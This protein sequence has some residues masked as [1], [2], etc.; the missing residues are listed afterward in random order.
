MKTYFRIFCYVMII[1][2]FT[3]MYSCSPEDQEKTNVLFIAV[4]D[5]RPALACYGDGLA[6]TPNIDRLA[7]EGALFTNH[8][9]QAP[10]C[11][12]SRTSMLTGYRPDEVKVTNHATH[13]RD[14][15][16]EVVTLPELFKKEGYTTISLGKIF[17]YARGYNDTQSWDEEHFLKG[18]MSGYILQENR[19]IKGKAASSECVDVPDTAYLDGIIAEKAI[20]CLRSFKKN[21]TSFFLAAGFLKPHLPFNA[22]KK[23]WDLYDREIF[24]DIDQRDPPENAPSIAFHNC[25]ELR[26]YNDTPDE[27][28]LSEEKEKKLRHGYYA[29][30]SYVDEQIG[31]VLKTLDELGLR[32]NTLV[33][34]W[35]DHGYHLGE[36][37][38]WCKSTN[39]EFSAR[40]PLIISAPGEAKRGITIDAF[41]ESV[42]IYPTIIDLCGLSSPNELAGISLEPLLQDPVKKWNDKAFNQFVRPYRAAIGGKEPMTHMGYSVRTDGY[43]YTSWYNVASGS[44]EY[45]ELYRLTDDHKISDNLAGQPDYAELE[46]EYARAVLDYKNGVYKKTGFK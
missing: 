27:W 24:G 36:Q 19:D 28:P 31:K 6:I 35:G 44:F 42:D 12:P 16:Q 11:A 9:V 33:V 18:Y 25:Q 13:F 5:L 37:N 26:G 17:H 34:F 45:P 20:E 15:R 38:L 43:R 23:Y 22:P 30:V 40:S 14:T 39:F 10:S 1:G 4:D 2:T 21:N 29:C 7:G 8:Y 32:E 41:A 46:K 3:G